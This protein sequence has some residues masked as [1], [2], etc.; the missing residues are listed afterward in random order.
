MLYVCVINNSDPETASFVLHTRKIAWI[1]ACFQNRG[2]CW[3]CRSDTCK[4]IR[5]KYIALHKVNFLFVMGLSFLDFQI[6]YTDAQIFQFGGHD[7]L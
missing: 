4:P 5:N 6:L 3:A 2:L 7:V 1:L